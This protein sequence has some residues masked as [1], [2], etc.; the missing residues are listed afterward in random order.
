VK[1]LERSVLYRVDYLHD[2]LTEGWA[3]VA[4][5]MFA[6][7]VAWEVWTQRMVR[8]APSRHGGIGRKRSFK[9]RDKNVY[10]RRSNNVYTVAMV[11]KVARERYQMPADGFTVYP[12]ADHERMAFRAAHEGDRRPR[13]AVDDSPTTVIIPGRSIIQKPDAEPND[14]GFVGVTGST[15]DTGDTWASWRE[16]EVGLARHGVQPRG[17]HTAGTEP[18][19]L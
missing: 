3:A 15:W 7:G 12:L 11:L 2:S 16:Y 8:R 14:A 18:I 13:H 1:A 5:F 6:L 9:R 10:S 17:P 19:A 4:Y